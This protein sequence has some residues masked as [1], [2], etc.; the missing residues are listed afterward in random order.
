MLS[1]RGSFE[2]PHLQSMV[3][4]YA[5]GGVCLLQKGTLLALPDTTLSPGIFTILANVWRIRVCLLCSFHL[6]LLSNARIG[7]YSPLC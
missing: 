7:T 6:V 4:Q 2:G 5:R 1:Y 3:L